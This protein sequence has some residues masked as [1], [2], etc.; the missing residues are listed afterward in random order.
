MRAA[1]I[2]LLTRNEEVTTN[3]AIKLQDFMEAKV[4]KR[5][6]HRDSTA[7]WL[8][9]T[10]RLLKKE[11]A[12]KPLIEAHRAELKKPLPQNWEYGY[13]YYTSRLTREATAFTI[14]C[15]HFP[16]IAKTLTYEEMRPLTEMI[17]QA[18]F[19]T[20][21]AAWSV[22]ALKAYSDLATDNGVKAG[23]ASVQGQ[24]VKVLGEPQAGQL[25]VTVPEGIARFFFSEGAPEGLGAWFQTIEKGYAKKS[26]RRAEFDAHRGAARARRC[27][28]PS[29]DP[30][31]ARRD[32]VRED[33]HTE[34]DQD[35]PTE[36]CDHRNVAGRIRVRTAGR[37]RFAAAR[38]E[39]PP[40][41]RLH[42]SP[43]RPC[44]GLS[45]PA[46]AGIAII[47]IRAAADLCRN[48]HRPPTLRRG[49]V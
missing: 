28:R 43:R 1:A 49:H 7:A 19:H 9:A 21:S 29:R 3:Y 5:L 47:E 10:W 20:L 11:S 37:A 45:R 30:G 16:E 44:T 8:A 32:P 40:G 33:H 13:Y 26:A 4:P 35:R 48:L 38:P 41:H 25:K 23:I 42:R 15:R 2:Y 31:Q 22:Q 34:P 6:W 17:E 12:A 18:D 24:D 39:L 27:R 14:L 36:P 46:F